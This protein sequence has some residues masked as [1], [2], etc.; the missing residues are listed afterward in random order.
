VHLAGMPVGQPALVAGHR[1]RER[2]PE[3]VPR[4]HSRRIAHGGIRPF[5]EGPRRRLCARPPGRRDHGRLDHTFARRSAGAD[6][7]RGRAFYRRCEDCS[8]DAPCPV[9]RV[10]AE[11]RDAIAAV[12]DAPFAHAAAPARRGGQA[13][14]CCKTA[15]RT[16]SVAP[17]KTAFV[18]GAGKRIGA[19]I[20]RRLARDGWRLALLA[21][22]SLEGL[23]RSPRKS[24]RAAARRRRSRSTSPIR[25]RARP[26]QRHR[27]GA[28][29]D[30]T[31]RQQRR[32]VRN[33][34]DREPRSGPLAAGSSR[35]TW[36]RRC[37][38]PRRSR[39]RC[40][41]IA[42]ARSSM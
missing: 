7:L 29:P 17:R 13:S 23:A 35:S 31:P 33:R 22:A 26:L 34:R 36:R 8:R 38:S 40:L 18:T 2:D 6:R 14:R 19:D 25:K 24:S 1:R 21:R 3:E 20:A 28:R 4:R 12:L 10:M 5:Q 42:R 32:D 27:G 37:F 15:D 30:R 16:R 41:K 39:R 9:Q 11:V